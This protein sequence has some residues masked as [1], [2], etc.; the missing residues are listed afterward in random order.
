MDMKRHISPSCEG[1]LLVRAA[2]QGRAT[3]TRSYQEENES[4]PTGDAVTAWQVNQLTA[5]AP[6][7]SR[8]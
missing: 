8:T 3:F 5:K 4:L 2:S 6:S 1:V 7:S